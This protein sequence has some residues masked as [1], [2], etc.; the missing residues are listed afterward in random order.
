V[1]HRENTESMPGR[2]RLRARPVRSTGGEEAEKRWR[3]RAK[4]IFLLQD[5]GGGALRYLQKTTSQRGR[6]INSDSMGAER[7]LSR[8]DSTDCAPSHRGNAIQD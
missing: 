6:Y 7:Q 5:L 4:Y 1:L 2:E 8:Y 3:E